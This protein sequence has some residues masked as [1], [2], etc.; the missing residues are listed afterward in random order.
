M[1]ETVAPSE[2]RHASLTGPEL[3]RLRAKALRTWRSLGH[4]FSGARSLDMVDRG[5][6]GW[7]ENIISSKRYKALIDLTA[8][9][10]KSLA[11]AKLFVLDDGSSL[12]LREPSPYLDGKYDVGDV[13]PVMPGTYFLDPRA[14]QKMLA[15]TRRLSDP[16][17]LFLSGWKLSKAVPGSYPLQL[18]PSELRVEA[19]ASQGCLKLKPGH[20]LQDI[21]FQ[22]NRDAIEMFLWLSTT[23]IAKVSTP[24]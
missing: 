13:R 14:A 24:R 8:T 18:D 6:H 22:D 11:G 7:L 12:M 9:S 5:I 2:A 21:S 16:R 15:D 17:K 3:T 20:D 23:P 19:F 10:A 4:E 1:P